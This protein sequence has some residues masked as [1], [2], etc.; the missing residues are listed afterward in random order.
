MAEHKIYFS[1]GGT[2]DIQR[3]IRRSIETALETENVQTP[4]SVSVLLTDD[5]QIHEI[6]LEQRGVDAP[7][8]VLSFPMNEFVPGA[9]DPEGAEWDY[10]DRCI[11]LGDVVLSLERAR[12]QGE[13]FGHGTEREISYLTVHSILHLLGYD[14]MDEGEQKRQMRAQ[15]EQIMQKLGL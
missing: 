14:H 10:D 4:C 6:N 8:D 7:T 3:L 15:E 5:R 1:G 9:F 12:A 13:E 11:P 2:A